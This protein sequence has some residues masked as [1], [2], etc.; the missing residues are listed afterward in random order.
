MAFF[1]NLKMT[2]FTI[3]DNIFSRALV[4]IF[5]KWYI[6]WQTRPNL[7]FLDKSGF[8]CYDIFVCQQW[9]SHVLTDLLIP[10]SFCIP[11]DGI[12]H[13][14]WPLCGSI[15]WQWH[16]HSLT[17]PVPRNCQGKGVWISCNYIH[18]W[19]NGKRSNLQTAKK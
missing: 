11:L 14:P 13:L 2:F 15:S 5:M 19:G 10:S 4:M 3:L 6:F 9:L 1:S 18:S 16:L 12:G 7:C 17:A 8:N